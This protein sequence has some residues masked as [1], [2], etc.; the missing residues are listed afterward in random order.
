MLLVTQGKRR[1]WQL[2]YNKKT[3]EYVCFHNG[4]EQWREKGDDSL[5]NYF[6]EIRANI[7]TLEESEI[8]KLPTNHIWEKYTNH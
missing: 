1:E 5:L 6:N 4:Q 7:H 8:A 3:K 2:G